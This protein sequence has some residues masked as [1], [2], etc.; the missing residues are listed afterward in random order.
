MTHDSTNQHL[1]LE[2]DYDGFDPLEDFEDDATEVEGR[3]DEFVATVSAAEDALAHDAMAPATPAICEKPAEE[4]IADLLEAMAPRRTVLLGI[5]AACETP[6]ATSV[7][8]EAVE[9][10]SGRKFS[11]YTPSNFCTMLEVAGGLARVTAAGEP[12]TDEVRAPEMVEV[13]GRAFWRPTTPPPVYWQTTEAGATVLA[14]DDPAARI[15]RLFAKEP[16][17]LPVYKRILLM[18]DTDEGTSMGL[19]S[20]AVDTDPAIAENRRFYVQHFVESLERA[21]AF[22]WADGATDAGRAALTGALAEVIDDYEVPAVDDVTCANV[23]T[24]TDGVNW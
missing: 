9:R 5:L 13:D 15:E 23:P 24:L 2:P 21:G 11:V 3:A 4:R 8:K 14:E 1:S 10:I 17:F 7:M 19:M 6:M 22:V 16:E 18:A 20:V 12:Y